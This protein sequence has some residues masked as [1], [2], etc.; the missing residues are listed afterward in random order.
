MKRVLI[1]GC[2]GSGKSTMAR[3]LHHL[4]GLPIIH[5]DKEYWKPNWIETTPT[6]WEQIIRRLVHRPTWIMD[7]NFAGTLNLRIPAADTI[8]FLDYPTLIC[9]YR[10]IK[11]MIRYWGRSRPDMTEGCNERFDWPFFHFIL[12]YRTKRRQDILEKLRAAPTHKSTYI[13]KNDQQVKDYL[14]TCQNEM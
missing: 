2:S 14:Q 11:R 8:I 12:T 5:L 13:F 1:I 3:K 6:E 7:G 9:I 10:T 4:T